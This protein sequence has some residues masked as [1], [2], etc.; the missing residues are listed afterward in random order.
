MKRALGLVALVA[1]TGALAG[2]ASSDDRDA[3]S[4]KVPGA[5]RGDDSSD[6]GRAGEKR[7][8]KLR[9]KDSPYGPVLFADGFPAYLFT[10]DS[11]SKSNCRGE[12]AEAWPP[13]RA[14]RGVEAGR[15]VKERLLGTTRRAGGA[16]QITYDGHPLYGY[17]D[18]PRGEVLCHDVVQFHGTWLAVRRSGAPAP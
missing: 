16:M 3:A 10:R 1:L 2:A 11:G 14:G 5:G 15:G 7:G 4:A 18:D 9:L 17:V 13:L 6:L 12:C 8:T